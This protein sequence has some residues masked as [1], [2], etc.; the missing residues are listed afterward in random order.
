MLFK[1]TIIFLLI[2]CVV[3]IFIYY[4]FTYKRLFIISKPTFIGPITEIIEDASKN[5]NTDNIEV[6]KQIH[7]LQK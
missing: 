2:I 3:S 1:L 6:S 5:M 7:S 4:T